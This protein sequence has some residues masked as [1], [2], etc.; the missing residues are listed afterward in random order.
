MVL[1][2]CLLDRILLASFCV[3]GL[4]LDCVVYV[5]FRDHALGLCLYPLLFHCVCRNYFGLLL[6]AFVVQLVLYPPRVPMLP[7]F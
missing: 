3:K 5:S 7:F 6:A 1:C 4:I 2:H